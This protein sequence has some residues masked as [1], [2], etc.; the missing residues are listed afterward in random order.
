LKFL[1][2]KWLNSKQELILL[3]QFLNG[4]VRTF[5]KGRF[6]ASLFYF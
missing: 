3:M 6:C 5:K 4:K 2:K 1:Q